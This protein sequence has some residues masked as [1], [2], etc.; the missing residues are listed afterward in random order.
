[1]VNSPSTM[2][3]A[4][5]LWN[6]R[7]SHEGLASDGGEWVNYQRYLGQDDEQGRVLRTRMG[8]SEAPLRNYFT[9]WTDYMTAGN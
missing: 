6:F 9:A 8:T 7:K 1:M 5:D 2:V 3:N 4:D